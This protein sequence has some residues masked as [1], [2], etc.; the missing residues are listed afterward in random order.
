MSMLQ[1]VAIISCQQPLLDLFSL[2][3]YRAALCCGVC[4]CVAACCS[5]LHCVLVCCGVLQSFRGC[6]LPSLDFAYFSSQL[7]HLCMYLDSN[8]LQ[9][10]T[11]HC[12]IPSH[13]ATHFNTIQHKNLCIHL[14]SISISMPY[15]LTNLPLHVSVRMC[16]CIRHCILWGGQKRRT[17]KRENERE[18]C[19]EAIKMRY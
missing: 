8:A 3:L 9:H 7:R 12:T 14:R 4:Q 19:R 6:R 13:T 10:P 1:C 11:A 17:E 2:V 18:R 5:M 16:R 15:S